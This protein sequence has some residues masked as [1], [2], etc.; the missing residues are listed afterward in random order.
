MQRGQNPNPNLRPWPKGVS[1]N[2]GGRPKALREVT[3]L[4]RECSEDAINTLWHIMT[5]SRNEAARIRAAEAILA[6]AWGKASPDIVRR[7]RHE[8]ERAVSKALRRAA[9]ARVTT[10]C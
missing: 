8:I 1:G 9:G 4:A 5:H 3:R 6:R 7:V 10:S 2:P